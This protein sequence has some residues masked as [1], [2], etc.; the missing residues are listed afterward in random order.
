MTLFALNILFSI[1]W[2]ALWGELGLANL[3]AGFVLGFFGLRLVRGL[4][5]A[6]QQGYFRALPQSLYLAAYFFKE[7]CKSCIQV[8]RDCV[9]R[10][11]NINPTIVHMPLD[12]KTDIEIFLVANL[13]TLTPGTLT[14]D[15]SEDR[16][17][18]VVHSIYGG[19]DD[20][21]IA[22]LKAGMEAHV[23]KVFHP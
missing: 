3:L 23:M 9:A 14:L 12:V 2:G 19:D 5:P 15:V 17:Y 13:I 8:A 1:A 6:S 16:S 18:L 22:D 20:A 7:L 4:I 21:L 10:R 11:P